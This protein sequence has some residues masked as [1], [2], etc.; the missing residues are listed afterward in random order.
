MENLLLSLKLNAIVNQL[1]NSSS[2]GM[3]NHNFNDNY[4][5]AADNSHRT[6]TSDH[7]HDRESVQANFNTNCNGTPGVSST[8]AITTSRVPNIT[9]T[10]APS[11]TS[12][13][14]STY[15]S[16]A[17]QDDDTIAQRCNASS[18]VSALHKDIAIDNSS[19]SSMPNALAKPQLLQSTAAA[20]DATLTLTPAAT[21]GQKAKKANLKRAR[22]TDSSP[23]SQHQLQEVDDQQALA[24]AHANASNLLPKAVA[25]RNR[26]TRRAVAMAASHVQSHN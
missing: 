21:P 4:S 20:A 19:S 16:A 7:T 8:I 1:G 25:S 3:D 26:N 10:N 9:Q 12:N 17:V 5:P 18:G 14:V 13:S 23:E 22:S 2:T 6:Y 24:V 11:G 15:V